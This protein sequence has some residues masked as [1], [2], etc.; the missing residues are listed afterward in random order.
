[1]DQNKQ[2]GKSV[3]FP[4]DEDVQSDEQR[5]KSDKL[6]SHGTSVHVKDLEW[7]IKGT[8]ALPSDSEDN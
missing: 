8:R 7:K 5:N 4:E 3:V 1:M 2:L 6:Q